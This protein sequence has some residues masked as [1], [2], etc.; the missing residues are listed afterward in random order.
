MLYISPLFRELV[1]EAVRIGQLRSRNRLHCALR[2]LILSQL[3]IPYAPGLVVLSFYRTVF[4]HHG[5]IVDSFSMR[6]LSSVGTKKKRSIKP[7]AIST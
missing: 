3:R 5:N 7:S 2:D 1:V 6:K 4:C